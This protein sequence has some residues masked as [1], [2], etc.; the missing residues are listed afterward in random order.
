MT[1]KDKVSFVANR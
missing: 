1:T